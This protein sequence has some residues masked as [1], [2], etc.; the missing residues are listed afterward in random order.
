MGDMIRDAVPPEPHD[1]Y[2]QFL[3]HPSIKPYTDAFQI[4]TDPPEW[5]VEME[6]AEFES[7]KAQVESWWHRSRC[8]LLDRKT[9]RLFVSTISNFRNW[10]LLRGALIAN[11]NAQWRLRRRLSATSAM[12]ELFQWLD[13]QP[14]P[15][16]SGQSEGLGSQVQCKAGHRRVC[17]GGGIEVMQP[18][19]PS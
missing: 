12:E 13:S 10:L 14:T 11:G 4:E 16:I 6:I 7:Y 19:K 17:C 5:L 1:L 8:L 2:R 9:R 15:T 3:L 18:A